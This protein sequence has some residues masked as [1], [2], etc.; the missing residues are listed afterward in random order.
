MDGIKTSRSAKRCSE[1]VDIKGISSVGL[2]TW[3]VKHPTLTTR[4]IPRKNIPGPVAEVPLVMDGAPSQE[5][6]TEAVDQ[7]PAPGPVVIQ[8]EDSGARQGPTRTHL[9]RR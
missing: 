1:H 6:P 3:E 2:H 8:G 9:P 7:G 4:A 5:Q